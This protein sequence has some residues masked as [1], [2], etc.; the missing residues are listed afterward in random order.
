MEQDDPYSAVDSF[1][2]AIRLNPAY[3]DARLGMAEALFLLAEFD[4]AAREIEEARNYAAGRRDLQLLEAR[5]FT[6]LR[7]YEE[8]Q[9]IY[10]GILNRRP[11]DGAANRGLAEIYALLGQKEL[12]EEAYDLSLRFSP[13][14]RRA[15]LQLVILHD[16]ARERD[17]A[18]AALQEVLRLFPDSLEVRIQAAE[19]YALYEQ[20]R[21]AMDH[22]SRARSM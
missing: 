13:G 2:S 11:H 21:S 4:E 10:T 1:R 5:I 12:A 8:A 7:R 9:A 22:L 6:A 3:A 18:D 20:W 17:K 14:N 16:E 15:L 19:H